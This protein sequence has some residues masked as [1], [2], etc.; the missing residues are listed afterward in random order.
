MSRTF[1][2]YSENLP[3]DETTERRIKEAEWQELQE[4]H[5]YNKNE[6]SN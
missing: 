1:D 3:L 2:F 4:I 5:K 6:K